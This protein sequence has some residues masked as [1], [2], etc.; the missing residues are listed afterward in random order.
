[1]PLACRR[2]QLAGS[3]LAWPFDVGPAEEDRHVF[4]L[5]SPEFDDGQEM[6]Q[7]YG[8]KIQN[9]SPPLEW[10]E[11]PEGTRSFALEFVDIH[12]IATDFVHWLVA[13]IDPQISTIPEGA[14]GGTSSGFTEVKPY[15]G[16]FPPS[17]THDYQ[18]TLYALRTDSLHVGPGAKLQEFRKA[19][20][21][22][23]LSKTTLIG[24][25]TKI[26]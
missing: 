5:R 12:P 16:P 26:K 2:L 14:A 25:F 1:V 4:R 13:D 18:F 10:H 8:K 24:K 3:S 19:A 23:L 22:N 17:G 9:V 11:V 15:E 20:E 21:Q 7:K 6:A